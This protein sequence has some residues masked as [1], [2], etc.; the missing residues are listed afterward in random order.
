[1]AKQAAG[2]GFGS[3]VKKFEKQWNTAK[4]E[5]VG[6]ME[7]SIIPEGD[8]FVRVASA[9]AGVSKQG[10]GDPYVSV[11]FR[12][13]RGPE[14]GAR[15]SRYSGIKKDTDIEFLAKDF[16]RYGYEVEDLQITE[17]EEL[18]ADLNK[19]KP[20]LKVQ[21]KHEEYESKKTKKTEMSQRVYVQKVVEA[22][23]L[24]PGDDGDDASDKPK[25]GKPKP[26]PKKK[27]AAK[28]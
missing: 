15:L 27:A 5:K 22:K 21:I 7:D 3:A 2:G 9:R 10:K 24:P 1:M 20:Y 17:I 4:K 8:Y 19:S 11:N 26:A 16:Q 25:G 28:K 23:D 6:S 12:V 14:T 18:V 13:V